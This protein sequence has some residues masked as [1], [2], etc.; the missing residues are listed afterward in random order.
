MD[1]SQDPIAALENI[2]IDNNSAEVKNYKITLNVKIP[3][4][5][6][7]LVMYEIKK[8]AFRK[9]MHQSLHTKAHAWVD[10][11]IQLT[12]EF[13]KKTEDVIK[14]CDEPTFNSSNVLDYLENLHAFREEQKR[15]NSLDIGTNPMGPMTTLQIEC[16][17]LT[18]NLLRSLKIV[19]LPTEEEL[20]AQSD[21]NN[22]NK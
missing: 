19:D 16:I 1:E 10:P 22:I 14:Q 7:Y 17:L 21:I 6:K 18:N 20:P 9:N 15:I 8:E 11:Q 4:M 2:P 5:K 12:N 13:I 3:T